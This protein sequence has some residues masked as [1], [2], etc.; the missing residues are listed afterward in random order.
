MY[1][2]HTKNTYLC[3][4]VEADSLTPSIIWCAVVR[5]VFTDEEWEFRPHEMGALAEFI[6]TNNE[7][8]RTYW[9]GHNAIS[10]DIPT[11]NHLLDTNISVSNCVDT[12][13]L[14]YLYHPHMPGGHSLRAWGERLGDE[15]LEF[16]DFT[17]F[18]EEQLTYCKQDV[19]LTCKVFKVL[20]KRMNK[21][22][23]SELSCEIEH[24]IRYIIDD[25]KRN[26]ILFDE[27]QASILLA[28]FESRKSDLEQRIHT[29]FPPK[30]VVKGEYEYRVRRDGKPHATY[31]K[32]VALYPKITF[33]NSKRM[34]RTW[35]YKDFNIGSPKQRVEHLLALGWVPREFTPITKKGGGGNP[36][37]TE[38]QLIDF[39]L[40]SGIPEVEL[41]KDWMLY[42]NR[43]SSLKEWLGHVNPETG[44][45]HGT[46][47]SCGAGSRRM[48]HN[49]PN[50]ANI[51]S[52]GKPFGKEMRS[53]WT[54]PA[55]DKVLVGID[56]KGL[57]GRTMLHYLNNSAATDIF[58]SGDIHQ[59]NCDAIT[60]AVGFVVTRDTSE[61]SPNSAK[62]L[63]YAFLFGASNQKLGKMVGKGPKVGKLIRESIM[64]NVPGLKELI[65]DLE[66][67][68][69]KNDGFL[70][71]IDGGFVRCPSPHALL[72][73]KAQP[74]GAILMK[75]AT[76]L[77]YGFEVRSLGGVKMEESMDH[78]KVL[79]VLDVHD[80]TQWESDPYYATTCGQIYCNAITLA[81][82]LLKFNTK[83]EGAFSV[84]K[85][86]SMT[87]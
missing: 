66:E 68:Y 52:L 44:R 56:A 80:E 18:S 20:T 7:K 76:V 33:S 1:L 43:I 64:G 36:K 84:G 47:F 35:D 57:E 49:S 21:R 42:D 14:S 70:S 72:N 24:K 38:D 2:D 8:P 41:I 31:G 82:E 28:D 22:G 73:Y 61:E 16:D 26:G 34:Y 67:E 29:V 65:Q 19:A 48:R 83:H 71:C 11:L 3:I 5:N 23:F 9:V 15:K 32:H 39:A 40:E 13:V 74:A 50:T 59:L 86:W 4:D 53:L 30:L 75:L 55:D 79:K 60:A 12:L 62:N 78:S 27:V 17:Q 45:I 87:H 63:Y 54:V 85:N 81:G 10:F 37:V 58:M 46:V 77:A 6:N 25:Q 69:W 51:C